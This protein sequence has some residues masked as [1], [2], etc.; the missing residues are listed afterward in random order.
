MN[1]RV[2]PGTLLHGIP[3]MDE[4]DV[5]TTVHAEQIRK[6]RYTFADLDD[7]EKFYIPINAGEL[8]DKVVARVVTA[9]SA[10]TDVIIGDLVDPDG[11]LTTGVL[12]PATA[13]L[14]ADSK[15]DDGAFLHGYLPSAANAVVLTHNADPL[16]AGV[17]EVLVFVVNL[18]DSWRETVSDAVAP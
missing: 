2:I 5:Q 8:V 18:N 14:I 13:G 10:G 1:M 15:A 17:M 16:T 9:F 12:N 7:D 4:F 6:Y 11:F 3:S